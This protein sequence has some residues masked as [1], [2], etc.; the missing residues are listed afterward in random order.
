[1]KCLTMVCAVQVAET[2]LD[3]WAK[4]LIIT[5]CA[6][7][8]LILAIALVFYIVKNKGDS[9]KIISISLISLSNIT[10]HKYINSLFHLSVYCCILA[11]VNKYHSSVL[12]NWQQCT[13]VWPPILHFWPIA[14]GEKWRGSSVSPSASGTDLVKSVP[15]EDTPVE[16]QVTPPAK[17]LHIISYNELYGRRTSLLSPLEER[18][19]TIIDTMTPLRE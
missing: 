2:G 19:L 18:R 14:Y 10:V 12:V 16:H 5:F 11:S 6:L 7:V 4:A 15:R 8:V 3:T 1:M 17:K 13:L 9:G